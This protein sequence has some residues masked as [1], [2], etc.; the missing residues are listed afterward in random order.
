MPPFPLKCWLA[1]DQ[2]L[3]PM[4][5]TAAWPY[6]TTPH[7]ARSCAALWC[8]VGGNAGSDLSLAKPRARTRREDNDRLVPWEY[9]SHHSGRLFANVTGF[10]NT[11]DGSRAVGPPQT[12]GLFDVVGDDLRN[13]WIAAV[14]AGAGVF[15]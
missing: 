4:L 9:A 2:R 15:D 7:A 13:S 1:W 6:R 14:D 8:I 5:T 3:T 11:N 10:Q 12:P